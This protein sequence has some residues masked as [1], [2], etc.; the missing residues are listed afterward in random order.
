MTAKLLKTIGAASCFA[1]LSSMYLDYAVYIGFPSVVDRYSE[2]GRPFINYHHNAPR[3]RLLRSVPRCGW[4]HDLALLER[5]P[6]L[7]V[8]RN[9]Q[10]IKGFRYAE[11]DDLAMSSPLAGVGCRCV[12]QPRSE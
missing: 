4:R 11:R 7:L 1:F 12:I 10:I 3:L 9:R 8:W 6:F 2:A 5:W